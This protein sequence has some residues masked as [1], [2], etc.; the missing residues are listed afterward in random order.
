M[1]L[2]DFSPQDRKTPRTGQASGASIKKQNHGSRSSYPTQAQL[3]ASLERLSAVSDATWKNL[4]AR[5]AAKYLA[6]GTI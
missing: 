4:T 3:L 1:P 2:L 6:E 5:A